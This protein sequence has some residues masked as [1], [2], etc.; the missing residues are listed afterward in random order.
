VADP[1][2]GR[3]AQLFKSKFQDALLGTGFVPP[4][5]LQEIM[6]YWDQHQVMP[7]SLTQASIGSYGQGLGADALAILKKAFGSVLTPAQQLAKDR[8]EY[9]ASM[10]P[11]YQQEPNWTSAGVPTN[12]A[13][14]AYDKTNG[15]RPWGDAGLAQEAANAALLQT[16]AQVDPSGNPLPAT[17]PPPAGAAQNPT[18]EQV[19]SHPANAGYWQYNAQLG[20]WQWIAYPAGS[21]Q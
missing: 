18:P 13:A 1:F 4:A 12:A 14:Q 17:A 11:G 20:Q 16:P 3:P 7:S 19:A 9:W 15:V 6:S 5:V 10:Q 21:G 2:G 8:P